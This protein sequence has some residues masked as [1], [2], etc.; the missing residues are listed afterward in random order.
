ML[1]VVLPIILIIGT[2]TNIGLLSWDAAWIASTTYTPSEPLGG[3]IWVPNL[4]NLLVATALLATLIGVLAKVGWL[5]RLC[6]GDNTTLPNLVVTPNHRQRAFFP[7]SAVPMLPTL[8]LAVLWLVLSAL[9]YFGFN[10]LATHEGLEAVRNWLGFLSMMVHAVTTLLCFRLFR[11]SNELRARLKESATLTQAFVVMTAISTIAIF[12][13]NFSV[14]ET[15]H[16]GAV[17]YAKNTT[18]TFTLVDARW[19]SVSFLPDSGV[20]QRL[21]RRDSSPSTS[22]G[23][24]HCV[25][26]RRRHARRPRQTTGD[27][28]ASATHEG[29]LL[30]TSPSPRDR[31]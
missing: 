21:S 27:I 22:L 9:A 20:G 2:I 16:E 6:Y 14:V 31:G 29:C 30:Y 1:H 5:L 18:N 23:R 26:Q 19:W 28:H 12:A 10:S 3:P 4:I 15:F 13:I 8:K 17:Q 11:T 7:A 25:G 24:R